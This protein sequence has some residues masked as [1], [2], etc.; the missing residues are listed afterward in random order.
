MEENYI[1][2]G[3]RIFCR[4]LCGRGGGQ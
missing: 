2:C 3:S 4:I 1:F